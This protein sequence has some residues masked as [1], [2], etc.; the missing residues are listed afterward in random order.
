MST[1]P[2]IKASEEIRRRIPG[3]KLG[4]LHIRGTVVEKISPQWQ[5][6]YDDLEK[7]LK[8]KF[9]DRPPSADEVVKAV[10]GMSA[11]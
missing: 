2:S 4:L 10:R 1:V 7:L 5:A 3:I 6:L 11:G 8:Q 9:D